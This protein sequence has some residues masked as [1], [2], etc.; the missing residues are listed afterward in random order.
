MQMGRVVS[1]LYGAP[2]PEEPNQNPS[3]RE[4]LHHMITFN[5]RER[6]V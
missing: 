1:V 3:P 6:A 4:R 5:P 2:Y